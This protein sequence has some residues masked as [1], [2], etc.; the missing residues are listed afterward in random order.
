MRGSARFAAA[1]TAGADAGPV[2]RDHVPEVIHGAARFAAHFRLDQGEPM[3]IARLRIAVACV[4]LAFVALHSPSAAAAELAL[5]ETPRDVALA[6]IVS[7]RARIGFDPVVGNAVTW[8]ARGDRVLW[9]RV[10]GDDADAS[11][12]WVRLERQAI[13]HLQL[14]L[15]DA[16]GHAAAETGLNLAPPGRAP[17]QQSF[18]LPI[19]EG[20]GARPLYLRIEGRGFLYLQPELLDE[21]AVT[22]REQASASLDRGVQLLLGLVAIF[23]LVRQFRQPHTG[24]VLLTAAAV[25]VALASLATNGQLQRVPGSGAL[26][27]LGPRAVPALWLLACAPVLWSTRRYAG[28]DKHSPLLGGALRW[29]GIAFAV[30]GGVAFFMPPAMLMGMQVAALAGL[31]L[32][33]LACLGGLL[34]DPRSSSWGPVLVLA[35]LLAALAAIA[36]VHA[37]V[38]PPTL[39]SRRGFQAML[40]LLL[41]TYL[42]LPW[43]RDLV[44]ERAKLKRA[45]VPEPTTE[46]KIDKARE[47]LMASLQTG[48][49]N[50][51]E[52]DMEWIAYRR[53]LEGL[54]PVLPQVASAVVAMNYHHGDLLLVEPK[55]AEAR[56]KMLL[57]QRGPLL[58][59]L[60]RSK[61]PQQIA[62][63]FDGPDGPLSR[64]QLAIIPLP[65]DKPGWGALLVERNAS[66]DYSELELDL[67]AEFAALAFTAGDEAAMELEARQVN[68]F[69]AESGVYKRE[70]IEKALRQ[71]HEAAF[72]Q[73]KPLA[74]LRVGLDDRSASIHT[75]AELVRDEIDY[76]E[77]VGRYGSDELLVLMPD[78]T[79]ADARQLGE[80]LLAVARKANVGI[81]VG[82]AA[83]QPGERAATAMLDRAAQALAR[84]RAGGGNQ[85]QSAAGT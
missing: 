28:L 55:G 23:G 3:L 33:T 40:A 77:S 5:V 31:A 22:Q 49:E 50:A 74:V 34:A 79:P 41:A 47:Q 81:S 67:C 11:A 46:E 63:D 7:G 18:L 76:G 29:L 25:L 69:D 16:L 75:V 66:V 32:M 68:E 84:A 72:L 21:P 52:G 58:K 39:L 44:R 13:D 36:L 4:C 27:A 30:A 26:L 62:L 43:L 12:R 17:V 51:S 35:G 8:R 85:V 48:L 20:A 83:L 82:M 24:A 54:K 70:M 61:A 56:Y 42:A 78:L 37:H 38:L 73:R 6:D 15:P 2:A 10:R 64:V 1:T 71:A 59:N 60:S 80:R 57:Q 65:I 19:P 53:L 14:F 45:V 9:L